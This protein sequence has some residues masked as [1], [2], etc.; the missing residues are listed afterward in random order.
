MYALTRAEGLVGQMTD[1][2]SWDFKEW[3]WIWTCADTLLNLKKIL[4][5]LQLETLYVVANNK[6]N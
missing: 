5:F 4:I 1:F 2:D 3:L 6:W